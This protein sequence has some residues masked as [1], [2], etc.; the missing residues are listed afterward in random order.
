MLA[1]HAVGFQLVEL[2][3]TQGGADPDIDPPPVLEDRLEPVGRLDVVQPFVQELGQ[4]RPAPVEQSHL[5]LGHEAPRGPPSGGSVPDED[6]GGL[7]GAARRRIT[8]GDGPE[9]PPP[10]PGGRSRIVPVDTG[11][12]LPRS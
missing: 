2:D 7:A 6:L 4:E 12:V 11:F 1:V 10:D 9:L 5:D 3:R 8:P